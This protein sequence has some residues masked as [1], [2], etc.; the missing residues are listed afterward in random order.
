MRW[1]SQ[2]NDLDEILT[3]ANSADIGS[4][5]IFGGVDGTL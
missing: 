1:N 5:Q 4:I 2:H 3:R